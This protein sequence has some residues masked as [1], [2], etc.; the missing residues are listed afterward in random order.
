MALRRAIAIAGVLVLRGVG[1]FA[2]ARLLTGASCLPALRVA[3]SSVSTRRLH[4]TLGLQRG[5]VTCIHVHVE[6]M[7]GP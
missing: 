4:V 6:S 3:A 1:A 7:D 5:D 2:P